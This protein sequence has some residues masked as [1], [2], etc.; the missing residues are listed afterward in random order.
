MD[1]NEIRRQI[2]ALPALP[3]ITAR[4]MLTAQA[5]KLT[6]TDR[7]AVKARC[8]FLRSIDLPAFVSLTVQ[9][10]RGARLGDLT[11]SL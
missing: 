8:D 1:I 9:D 6:G 11:Y 10:E 7:E 5:Y 4:S 3:V 2:A